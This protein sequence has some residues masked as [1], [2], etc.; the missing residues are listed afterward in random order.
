MRARY[1][2]IALLAA[3]GASVARQRLRLAPSSSRGPPDHPR[4]LRRSSQGAAR[5]ADLSS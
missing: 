5:P 3:F 2:L 4:H 1:F